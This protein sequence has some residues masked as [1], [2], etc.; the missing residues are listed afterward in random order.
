M[1]GG[2]GVGGI[3]KIASEV[4]NKL[5]ALPFHS[6]L[7]VICG[8]NKRMLESLSKRFSKEF[9]EF[10]KKNVIIKGF[11]HNIDEFMSA[12]DCLITKAGPGTIAE[13]MIRGLPMV[14]S[15]FLPGQVRFTLSLF[16]FLFYSLISLFLLLL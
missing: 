6:Q 1:G 2:D 4:A 15:S 9:Q 12:A 10:S 8:N 16:L 5:K 13:S 14:I 11:V 3:S 7:V